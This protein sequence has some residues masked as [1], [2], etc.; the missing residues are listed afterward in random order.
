MGSCF[1]EC[2]LHQI[3]W[4]TSLKGVFLQPLTFSSNSILGEFVLNITA[5][6]VLL[7]KYR[8]CFLKI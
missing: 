8:V 6:S 2:F 7:S 4:V 1:S 5:S 3:F